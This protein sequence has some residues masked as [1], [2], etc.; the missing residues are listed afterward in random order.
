MNAESAFRNNLEYSLNSNLA[1]VILFQCAAANKATIIDGENNGIEQWFII[2]VKRAVDEY[3]KPIFRFRHSLLC[4]SRVRGLRA[5]R[6]DTATCHFFDCFP[7]GGRRNCTCLGR[8]LNKSSAPRRA[9]CVL[10]R[11]TFSHSHSRSL[12]RLIN[13]K[14]F[15]QSSQQPGAQIISDCQIAA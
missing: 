9:S 11:R 13:D 5:S 4:S 3:V 15:A 8:V 12:L 6:A 2:R 14:A 10:L 1:A 7:D